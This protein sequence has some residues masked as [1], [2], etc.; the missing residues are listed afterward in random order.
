MLLDQT[1]ERARVG[2]RCIDLSERSDRQRIRLLDQPTLGIIDAPP[3]I[4]EQAAIV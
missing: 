4:P 1:R 3:H 2:R